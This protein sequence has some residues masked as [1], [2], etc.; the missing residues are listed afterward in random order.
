MIVYFKLQ[1]E[2]WK[3]NRLT[4]PRHLSL[5]LEIRYGVKSFYHVITGIQVGCHL[6]ENGHSFENSKKAALF[7][8]NSYEIVT[9]VPQWFLHA[10]QDSKNFWDVFVNTWLDDKTHLEGFS[11][12]YETCS[13]A[14]KV[15]Y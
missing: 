3:N 9:W 5:P 4:E 14:S 2:T 6:A 13:N 11:F 8:H 10:R 15:F 12:G 7:I 1:K